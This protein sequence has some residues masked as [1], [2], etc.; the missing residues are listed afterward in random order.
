MGTG[1]TKQMSVGNK[2]LDAEHKNLLSMVNDMERA[3]NAR[4]GDALLRTL[5]LFTDAIRVHFNNEARIAQ[6]INYS[7]ERHKAQHAY[8]LAEL[9]GINEIS[10]SWQGQWSESAVEYYYHFLSEWATEH[11]NEDDM[12]LKAALEAYPYDFNPPGQAG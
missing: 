1:W 6:A 11:I 10:A 4:N 5:K 8:V 2:S 3:I 12:K 7:F 9:R